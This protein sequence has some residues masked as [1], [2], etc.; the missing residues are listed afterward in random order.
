[1]CLFPIN[2]PITIWRFSATSRGRYFGRNPWLV[3]IPLNGMKHSMPSNAMNLIQWNGMEWNC[4]VFNWIQFKRNEHFI[5]SKIFIASQNQVRTPKTRHPHH[6]VATSAQS[7][8][9]A[10]AEKQAL[11]A[12]LEPRQQQTKPEHYPQGVVGKN[13]LHEV[14]REI[15]LTA[16]PTK[17]LSNRWS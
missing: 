9:P 12:L 3:L 11:I 15:N 1:M 16:K 14:W 7:T 2:V 5:I 13:V 6:T 10:H 17:T 4:I 8:H